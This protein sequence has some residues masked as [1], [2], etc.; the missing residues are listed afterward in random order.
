MHLEN[1][2][3]YLSY[4]S[5]QFKMKLPVK[6]KHD[7]MIFFPTACSITAAI[8]G[9]ADSSSAGRAHVRYDSTCI[10]LQTQRTQSGHSGSSPSHNNCENCISSLGQTSIS[11]KLR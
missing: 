1:S 9:K 10:R 4:K 2:P 5:A 8:P 6:F 3:D 7:R 11:L